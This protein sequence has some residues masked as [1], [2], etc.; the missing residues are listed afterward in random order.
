MKILYFKHKNISNH[1]TYDFNRAYILSTNTYLSNIKYDFVATHNHYITRAALSE[2]R[3]QC[4]AAMQ[5][6]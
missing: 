3:K 1:D 4:H 2:Q 5:Y 6:L